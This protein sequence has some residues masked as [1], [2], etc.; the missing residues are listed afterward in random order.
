MVGLSRLLSDTSL[1]M[2]EV[3]GGGVARAPERRVPRRI[4]ALQ[5]VFVAQGQAI[6]AG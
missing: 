1:R 6:L 4:A 5:P 2:P 3:V